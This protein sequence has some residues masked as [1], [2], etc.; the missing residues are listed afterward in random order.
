[1]MN[2]L[3][4]IRDRILPPIAPGIPL[5]AHVACLKLNTDLLELHMR[6][7]VMPSKSVDKRVLTQKTP[8]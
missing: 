6:D 2:L 8:M 1:M 5:P 4:T 7:A 3:R